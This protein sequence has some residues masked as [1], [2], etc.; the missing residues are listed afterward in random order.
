M[1]FPLDRQALEVLLADA[2]ERYKADLDRYVQIYT[3]SGIYLAVLA[4]YGNAL[5]RFLDRPPT[6][7]AAFVTGAFRV[8][9]GVL[10]VS[11]ILALFC[12]LIALWGRTMTYTLLPSDWI[13][14]VKKAEPWFKQAADQAGDSEVRR[15]DEALKERMLNRFAEAI[16]R[17]YKTSV[18]RIGYLHWASQ[19]LVAGF[20]GLLLSAGAYSLLVASAPPPLPSA[21]SSRAAPAVRAVDSA[22]IHSDNVGMAPTPNVT[23]TPPPAAPPTTGVG[24]GGQPRPS[25]PRLPPEPEPR[26]VRTV[27]DGEVRR[28][29]I[30]NE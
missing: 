25:P 1:G 17:N 28:G 12:T 11:A 3:R 30:L 5:V 14:Y 26:P 10:V 29:R 16:D 8:G 22:K 19:F 21:L 27:N 4:L 15:L 6:P 24:G 9:C 13:D 18:A 2:R 7:G 20:L 23:P